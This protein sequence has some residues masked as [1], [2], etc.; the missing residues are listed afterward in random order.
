M[1]RIGVDTGGTFTDTVILAPGGRVG[2]GKTLSTKHDLSQGILDSIE[3]AASTLG[4]SGP[5]A[6]ADAELI[7]HATTTGINALLTG[8]GARVGLLTTAGFEATVPIAKGNK[9]IGIDEEYRTEAAH[10]HKPPMLLPR[11][12]II[13]VRERIDAHGK[14]LLQLDEAHARASIRRLGDDDVEAVAIALLWSVID[15]RHE[16]RLAEI[17]AE[18]LPTVHVSLSHEVAPRIGEYERSVTVLLNAYVA[19]LVSRYIERLGQRFA[20]LG[21]TG[22]FVVT[23]T[24]G[25]VRDATRIA[26]TPVDTLNSGPVGGVAASLDLGRRLGHA[27][28][29]ATDV[30]GTSFD[31]GIVADGRLQFA[32]RPMIGMYPLATPVVDLTS[33]GTGGGSIAWID[34]T[35]GSLRVGPQSAG[36]DPGPVCYGRGGHLPTVTD[37]AVALGYLDRLG[38]QLTLD[39]S[40]ARAAIE[41]ELAEPMGKSVDEIADD[42][43]RVAN[44]QMADLVRRS[45]VQRGHDPADFALYAYGG[46]APQY[47]GRY[48]E[49]LGVREVV[50]PALASVFSA[51]GA[52]A[53]DLRSLAEIEL[54]PEPLER[55]VRWLPATLADLEARARRDITTDDADTITVERRV[56]LRFTRQMHALSIVLDDDLDPLA[57]A[58]RF[59][60]EYERLVGAGTAFESAGIELVAVSVEARAPVVA[61]TSIVG[62]SHAPTTGV[63]AVLHTR[64]AYFDGSRR[65]CPVYDGT[66]LPAGATIEGPA[67]VELPTTTLVV[68]PGQTAVQHESGDITLR[69]GG[70][71]TPS[72]APSSTARRELDPATFEV[73]RHRLSAI[74]DEAAVTIG[75]VSGSPIATE[76][77]DFNSGL[78]TADGE[79]VVAGVYVLV[80]AA[81]LGRIVR[82]IID[83]YSENP[84][85]GPG[86]MFI[87]N[88]PY[89]GAPHQADVVVVAPI[90]DG[91]RLIAWCG[92]CVHQADVGG[93]VPGSITVG[94]RNIYEEAMPISPVKIVERGVI[95]KDIEREYLARSRTP[96]LNRL[97]LLG[98]IAANRVQSERILDLC[99]KY[100]TDTVVAAFDRLIEATEARLRA[101]LRSLPDGVWRHVG[102]CEH[103]GVE[104]RVYAVRCTMTKRG[105]ALE[106]DFTESSDQAPALINTAEPTLS[107]YAMT[108]VMT[109]LGYDL[110][111]VPAAFWRVMSIKSRPGSVVHCTM[112]AGMSMGVTSAGQEVRT[113]VNIC[114]SRLLDASDD[115]LHGAQILAS[116]T[117]GSA[118]S[119]ISGTHEDGR[120]FGTMILDGVASGMGARTWGDGP[121]CGGFISS[122]SGSAVNV[123][124]SELHFP[125]RY[126][127]RR[128]RPDSGGPGAF[129]GGVGADNVYVLHHA[130]AE[131]VSTAFSHGV[132]PPTASGVAGGEP[133][134][135]NAFA[136]VRNG[137]SGADVDRM[138]EEFGGTV[139]WL[140]PKKVTSL[141]PADIFANYGAGGGGFG[142]PLTR[143]LD[144]VHHDV[145]EGLVSSVGARRD[146][147]V[148]VDADGSVDVAGSAAARG[149]RRQVPAAVNSLKG[150]RR[151]SSTLALLAGRVICRCCAHD[152]GPASNNVKERLVLDERSVGY[153]WSVIDTMSGASRFVV[154]RFACPGCSVQIDVEV[155]LAGSPFVW[156]ASLLEIE[157]DPQ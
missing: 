27:N 71:S 127:W 1:Y 109:V 57:L 40:A 17:V 133:G 140:P 132:Q 125:L 145:L 43:L 74:N 58:A 55:S 152:L 35:T 51:Y 89:V 70:L 93:P 13:G 149:E 120:P 113:A 15:P 142:D 26:R 154:R 94:A 84:G 138:I 50:V 92:S 147:G 99:A 25:G 18:E 34:H 22:R 119:C 155:N 134:M 3:R 66:S 6:I 73:L 83:N 77:N 64:N 136:V 45:T 115:P 126:L 111:W 16:L 12:R 150:S 61:T 130:G 75:R 62:S 86:D 9:V 153:R 148:V 41:R 116:C 7:A 101:R 90:F 54:R 108:A 95:R 76:G 37:A 52:A 2:V 8:T 141:A 146:Y 122:P 97:D 31:V 28:V 32:R 79:T 65:D 87:T 29:V 60:H 106:F 36:A 139:E 103:D 20:G 143:D 24:S 10:W 56:S 117:S 91:D 129:R 30:G 137:L 98:Q 82:D 157:G 88:D 144:R 121:D 21:F 4:I 49:D 14:V 112:P 114:V 105:D 11:R 19:P 48:A 59:R 107:G 104:D 23:Q 156:S 85:I 81:A 96:E 63:V 5:E 123:E 131:F 67:F 151:L 39:A 47:A 38:G 135:Q 42:I 80:H 128:E 44:A 78:M 72:I 100:G 118:T 46:A 53:T 33:I 69:I 68:Y 102:F 124:V 110:P